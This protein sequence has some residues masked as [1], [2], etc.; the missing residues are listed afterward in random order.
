MQEILE[1]ELRLQLGQMSMR[2]NL[3]FQHENFE[4]Q[5]HALVS[6]LNIWIGARTEIMT[7]LTDGRF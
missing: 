5:D 2:R 4:W 6:T 1:C 7:E 3:L